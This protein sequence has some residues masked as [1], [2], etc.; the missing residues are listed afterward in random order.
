[1]KEEESIEEVL[2]TGTQAT[3][4]KKLNPVSEILFILLMFVVTI[5]LTYFL[6]LAFVTTAIVVVVLAIIYGVCHS[7]LEIFRL[8]KR[9]RRVYHKRKFWK[10]RWKKRQRKQ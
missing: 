6:C 1:M 4:E 7:V 10:R 9:K 3:R 8:F 5:C 2:E